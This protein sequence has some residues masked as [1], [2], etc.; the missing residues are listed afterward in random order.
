MTT[1][2]S[3]PS[4]RALEVLR[5]NVIRIGAPISAE[6]LW[7]R[8]LTAEDQ[9]RLGGDLATA[10]ERLGTAGMWAEVRGVS[11]QRAV[12][13]VA[14]KLGFLRDDDSEW[15]L[16]E[17][18]EIVEVDEAVASGDF[19]LVERPREA[20]WNTEKMEV[21]WNK[22]A[23]VWNLLWELGRHAK[24]GQPIDRF[25][26]GENAHTNVVTKLKSRLLSMDQFPVDLGDFIEVVGRGS[27]QLKLPAERI[28][29]FVCSGLETLCEWHP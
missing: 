1:V 26:F 27:Q 16:R 20:Y 10:Y 24:A 13:E 21:D 28:R 15:L 6:R 17:I 7:D 8:H 25:T 14:K 18:G 5:D 11:L 9:R 22:H 2:N 29:I 12:V 23:A 19:V 3:E 4:H